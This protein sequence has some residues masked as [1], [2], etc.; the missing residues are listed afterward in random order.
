[1]IL[2][3][4]V[5]WMMAFGGV[6]AGAPFFDPLMP[7]HGTSVKVGEDDV[8]ARGLLVRVSEGVWVV[9]DQELLRPA[10]WFA[11]RA[12]EEPVSLELMAQASW[13]EP[14]KKAG[15]KV[16]VPNGRVM[17]MVSA[18]PGVGVR[19]GAVV[20]DPRPRYGRESGRGGLEG[21]GRKFLGYDVSGEVPVLSYE[22]DGVVVR[23]WYGMQRDGVVRHLAVGPGAELVFMVAAGDAGRVVSNHSGLVLEA[24]DGLLLGRLAASVNERRVGL[25]YFQGAGGVVGNTL[26]APSGNKLRWPQTI[27]TKLLEA[28]KSGPGW[29]L[30]GVDLPLANP[31]GRRMRPA[32]LAFLPSGEAAVVTFEGDVWRMRVEG[33]VVVWRRIAAGLCEPL[34]IG[35][36]G[37]VVQVFTRNGLVRLRDT[38]G[39]GETDFY[40]NHSSLMVQ[41]TSTRGYPLDMEM[42]GEGRTW[43]SFG[44]IATTDKGLSRDA[45]ADPH[46]GGILAI[47]AD[48]RELEVIASHARE[49]FIGYDREGRRLAMSD[50]Q[51]QYVPSSGIFP[52]VKG[53]A[54]G[55][56][57]K[58]EERMILPAVWIPHEQ[59][60]SS[61]SPLWLDGGT[62]FGSW[63]GGL[64]NISYGTGR[65]FLVRPG[66][67]WPSTRGAVIPLGIETELPL[68]HG[69]AN[70]ADGSVWLAGFR[71]YDSRVAP[72]EGIGRLRRTEGALGAPVDAA[73]FGE[74]VVITLDAAIDEESANVRNFRVAE[75][76]YKRTPRYGSPRYKRDGGEGVDRVGTAMTLLSRDGRSVFLHIPGL[77][78]TM[79]LEVAHGLK[80]GGVG[81][82]VPVVYFSAAEL[83][84]L[85]WEELG[86]D[87]PNLEGMVAVLWDDGAVEVE[88]SAEFGRE[89]ATR[90]GCVACHSVDG[91][92]EGHSGPT[93]KGLAG[94]MRKFRDGSSR[95]ADRDYLRAAILTP[96]VSVV[97]GYD[98]GMASYAGVLGE[99]EL[100]SVILFIESL[101]ERP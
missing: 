70:P 86:F 43:I 53:G 9:F 25:G 27:R 67:G 14:T 20:T 47:S 44:G 7:V 80:T 88:P 41:T 79:Q 77:K 87:Q 30:D 31:W 65:L 99:A 12:G 84:P 62:A 29:A 37:G 75:W 76:Q 23:E 61:G 97:E 74:G 63:E 26:G 72:L 45:P 82:V 49:P 28:Q 78:P 95:V 19:E 21:S 54:Y 15:V 42:D 73:I 56:G 24:K 48:G 40:E 101:G 22:V 83:S 39:N 36:V 96:E 46:S 32:D 51:G 68:L 66:G 89:I 91:R 11:S 2:R 55:Y 38:N 34:S 17:P 100:E 92:Q 59:D 13:V 64:L 8:L 1:M 94:S 6:V 4:M 90:F 57:G 98:L 50:Q 3:L 18:L 81:A 93:W 58:G 10:G 85:P 5:V 35:Q 60:T 52:V 71:I 33:D 69:R 16:P